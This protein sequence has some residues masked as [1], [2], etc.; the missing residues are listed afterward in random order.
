[1]YTGATKAADVV[2]N[3]SIADFE[4]TGLLRLADQYL[5]DHPTGKLHDEVQKQVNLLV[6]PLAG[7]QRFSEKGSL[8]YGT[9]HLDRPRLLLP[10]DAAT[11]Q[12]LWADG[13]TSTSPVV[14]FEYDDTTVAGTDITLYYPSWWAAD[15]P[16]RARLDPILQAAALAVQTY[17]AYGPNPL[18]PVTM[19]FTQLP[20]RDPET[21]NRS[22]DLLAMAVPVGPSPLNCYVGIFPS[23][24]TKTV[25]QSQQAL[26]HE[27]FHCYQYQNLSAQENNPAREANQWWVEGSAE[28]FSNVVYPA[29][30]FEWRWLGQV[31][32]VMQGENLFAWEYKAFIFFQYLENRP[33]V[34]LNGVLDLLRA[35]PTAAGS[36]VNQQMAAL[37][38]RPN[39]ATIF[40]EFG[41]AVADQ[42]ILDSAPGHPAIP[43]AIPFNPADIT[44]ATPGDIFGRGPFTIDIRRVIFPRAQDYDLTISNLG[45]PG[46]AS[47]RLESTPRAWGPLPSPVAAGCGEMRYLVVATQIGASSDTPYEYELRAAA[48]PS[49][50]QCSCLTG[51]WLLDNGSYLTHLNE[52]IAQAAPGTVDYTGVQGSDIT[53]FTSDGHLNQTLSNLV[54]NA[55][56][57]VSGLPTQ[58]LVVT[59]DGSTGAGYTAVEGQ[60]TYTSVE[61]NLTISTELNGQP[62]GSPSGDYFSSG[63][64]G[65]G[66]TFVCSDN[67]L[68]LIPVYPGYTNLPPLTFSRQP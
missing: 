43:L 44:E 31:T 62:L 53:T 60:L 8:S 68:T 47:A 3:T 41:Q 34:G 16:N 42:N 12:R 26:A 64:L 36:G 24:F 59:M 9:G 10:G 39:M 54:I 57:N 4:A 6:A 17:N 46:L 11:C 50:D 37:S 58:T 1:M 66:A 38:A 7:L 15:D 21:G 27:M 13:F 35:M 40:H 52:L 63:P 2:G 28:Y 33:D 30:N 45:D 51:S 22:A 18:P 29:V 32:E 23:L 19:V 55:E 49:T 20:G 25:E 61:T 48:R 67:T 56:M 14:C 65:T 5:V